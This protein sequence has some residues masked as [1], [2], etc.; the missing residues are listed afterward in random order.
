[1]IWHEYFWIYNHPSYDG[2]GSPTLEEHERVTSPDFEE[3]MAL[4]QGIEMWLSDPMG[5]QNTTEES[6]DVLCRSAPDRPKEKA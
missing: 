2:E 3:W 1:M 4:I 6:Y 5:P